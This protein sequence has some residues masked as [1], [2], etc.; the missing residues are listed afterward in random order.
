MSTASLPE[1][2]RSL[3]VHE[4]DMTSTLEGFHAS[5][6]RIRP[7]HQVIDDALCSREVVLERETDGAPVEFGASC[8]HLGRLPEAV[9]HEI[10]EARRPLGGILNEHRIPY[11]SRPGRY[12]SVEPDSVIREAL[13]T[14]AGCR[15]YGR[16]NTL[17]WPDG[18][19]L[20]EIFEVL[21]SLN[22]Q[23]TGA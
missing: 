11:Q 9:R 13:K 18:E 2:Y 8:I 5:R 12:F 6:L 1:P 3:L 22:P 7:I 4:K 16:Q 15:C 14:P 20:A 10:R 23:G 21:P 17:R 19:V